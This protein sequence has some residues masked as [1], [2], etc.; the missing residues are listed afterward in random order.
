MNGCKFIEMFNKLKKSSS[1]S[2]DNILSFDEFR[3]YMHVIRATEIDLKVILAAVNSS[4]KKTL[5]FLCGSA[6]DGKSHLLSYLKNSDSDNLLDGYKVFNDA[7]ESNAPSKTAVET[8]CKRLEEFNDDNIDKPGSNAIIAINLGV[9]S[10]FI[11]SEYA[12]GF[13]LLKEYVKGSNI[14]TSEVTKTTYVEDSHFQHISFSDYHMFSLNK[15]EITPEYIEALFEK[16]ASDDENNIFYATYASD[17]STCSLCSQCPIRTNYEFLTDSKVRYY[18]ALMLVKVILQDKEILTT[19]ELLNYIYDI[20]VAP[21]FDYTKFYKCST[22]P[23]SFL[24]EYLNCIM[25]SLLFDN[26]DIS[27]IMNKTR[28]YD[29]LLNRNEKE[30]DI[31]IEYYVSEDITKI[32]KA[33]VEGSPYSAILCDPAYI[34]I[35]NEDK[36]IKSKLFNVLIR[37]RDLMNK[38]GY[39]PMFLKYISDLYNYNI[40]RTPKLANLYSDI[41][42]AV[43]HWCGNEDDDNICIDDSH[44]SF[45]IYEDIKFEPFLGNIPSTSETEKIEKFLPFIVAEFKNGTDTPIHIDIDYSLYEMIEKIKSGYVQTAED[46]NN[47]A[48]FISFISKILKTGSS[49]ESIT[50]LSEEGRKA[51][52]EKT[53]FG[54][55]KFKVVK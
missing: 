38:T 17:C 55:Y 53:I 24:K 9:L 28:K 21:R 49:N 33:I 43:I 48:D 8:L 19:R 31:A 1:D 26:V 6:G 7:T 39:E 51:I 15:G 18:I 36:T 4:D 47:H 45:S 54:T 41:K 37:I 23:S 13:G 50:I 10:N 46:R 32:V 30:D 27:V 14:M 16:I 34:D 20:V 52:L 40:G 29:P 35:L 5:V 22:N 42:D 25:P 3:K 44:K 12:S 11:E 2:I